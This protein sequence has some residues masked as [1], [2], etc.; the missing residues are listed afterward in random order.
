MLRARSTTLALVCVLFLSFSGWAV[1]IDPKIDSHPVIDQV[2]AAYEKAFNSGDVKQI[3]ELWKGDGEFINPMGDRILGREAIEKLFQDYFSRNPGVKLTIQVLSIKVEEEGRVVVAEVVPE[4]KPKPPGSL[5][6]NKAKVV[7]VRS[8]DKWLIEG[9][10]E[11]PYLPASYEHLKDLEWMVGSWTSQTPA[12]A[13]TDSDNPISINT[14]C[15]CTANKSFLTRT[16]NAR[17]QDLEVQGTEVIGWDPQAKT[18]RS[19]MFE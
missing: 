3:G 5:G 15:Q 11:E 18:I 8:D 19:W 13:A 12:D 4:V 1:E 6:T 14:T 2:F 16:F 17:L 7:L 9:I 10:K